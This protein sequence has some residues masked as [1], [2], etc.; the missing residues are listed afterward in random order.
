MGY[1][2]ILVCSSW[3]MS[4]LFRQFD[5]G[6]E[7]DSALLM[8]VGV[9]SVEAELE[10]PCRVPLGDDILQAGVKESGGSCPV[11][12]YGGRWSVRVTSGG[13][14]DAASRSS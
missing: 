11:L 8:P 2:V 7:E 10:H 12:G 9:F 13:S 4:H 5:G 6:S 14:V 1:R 3:L